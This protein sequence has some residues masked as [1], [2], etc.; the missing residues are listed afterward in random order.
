MLLYFAENIPGAT[1]KTVLVISDVQ[2]SQSAS[3]RIVGKSLQDSIEFTVEAAWSQSANI[4]NHS[5]ELMMEKQDH[6]ERKVI[7]MT[8][9]IR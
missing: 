4:N 9:L 7:M 8:E 5:N 6:H 1:N 3:R 2:P